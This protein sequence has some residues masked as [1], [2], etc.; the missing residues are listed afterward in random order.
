MREIASVLGIS[1]PKSSLS[2]LIT[3]RVA[4]GYDLVAGEVVGLALSQGASTF[5]FEAHA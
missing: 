3:G 4:S 2:F 1:S 5:L